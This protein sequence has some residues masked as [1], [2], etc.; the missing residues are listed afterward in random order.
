MSLFLVSSS[1]LIAVV[2]KCLRFEGFR[3]SLEERLDSGRRAYTLAAGVLLLELSIGLSMWTLAREPGALVLLVFLHCS[4]I[5]LVTGEPV[6]RAVVLP[7]CQCFGFGTSWSPVRWFATSALK[8]AWWALRNGAIAGL[9]IQVISPTIAIQRALAIGIAT[10]AF[11]SLSAMALAIH[12]LRRALVP[13]APLRS[14]ASSIA[15]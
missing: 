3:R 6:R 14:S 7:D 5:W 9:S 2:G 12:D 13:S 1:L 10:V 4:S 8:P 11:V 15:R